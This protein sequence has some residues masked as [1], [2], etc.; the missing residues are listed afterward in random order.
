MIR[1]R[2]IEYAKVVKSDFCI[3]PIYTFTSWTYRWITAEELV[4]GYCLIQFC[5]Y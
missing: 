3:L 5:S 2:S 1:P 4:L